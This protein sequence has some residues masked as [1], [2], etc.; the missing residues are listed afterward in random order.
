MEKMG[1]KVESGSGFTGL[2]VSCAYERER[3]LE[4]WWLGSPGVFSFC[5]RSTTSHCGPES[6][7]SFSWRDLEVV[8]MF[9]GLHHNTK[10]FPMPH[11]NSFKSINAFIYKVHMFQEPCALLLCWEVNNQPV[12]FFTMFPVGILGFAAAAGV[13]TGTWPEG[14]N[15]KGERWQHFLGEL[16]L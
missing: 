8:G 3:C 1:K 15:Q 12:S 9:M 11:N 14:A 6:T 2:I 16:V 5:L 7:I 13:S 4:R 10:I